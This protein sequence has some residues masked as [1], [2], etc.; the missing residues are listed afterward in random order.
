MTDN[1]L[2]TNQYGPVAA[3]VGA[4]SGNFK[5][6]AAKDWHCDARAAKP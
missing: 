6:I 3:E 5:A 1:E 2:L 4:I